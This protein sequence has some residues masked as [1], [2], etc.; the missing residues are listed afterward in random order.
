MVPFVH[1]IVL[2]GMR[3]LRDYKAQVRPDSETLGTASLFNIVTEYIN[4]RN[5]T[6]E[7]V[8]ELYLQHTEETTQ[9]FETDAIDYAFDQT[10][11]QP[12]LVNAIAREPV[13][14]ICKKDYTQVI[15]KNLI[16]LAIQDIILTRGTHFDSLIRK[17]KEPRIRKVIAPL[18]MGDEIMD[19]TDDDYLYTRNF[20]RPAT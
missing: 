5:F 7:E 10:Q 18:I 15:T 9:V 4:L 6:R 19:R 2:V 14:K 20:L 8:A 17:L 16:E 11:G 13:E 1:S 3:N 12:W